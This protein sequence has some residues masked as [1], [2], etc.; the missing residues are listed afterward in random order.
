MCN[1]IQL[2]DFYMTKIGIKKVDRSSLYLLALNQHKISVFQK[3]V[4]KIMKNRKSFQLYAYFLLSMTIFIIDLWLVSSSSKKNKSHNNCDHKT[5][6]RP[7][8]LSLIF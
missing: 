1:E 7:W 6:M 4:E 8:T 2:T 3:I 5:S